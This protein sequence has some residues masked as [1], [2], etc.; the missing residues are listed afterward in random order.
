MELVYL[1]FIPE[2]ACVHVRLRGC[3]C[4]SWRSRQGG[5]VGACSSQSGKVLLINPLRQANFKKTYLEQ[6]TNFYNMAGQFAE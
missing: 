1:S 4:A 6:N 2:S 3:Y 5:R